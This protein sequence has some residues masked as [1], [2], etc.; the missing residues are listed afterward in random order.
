MQD[1]SLVLPHLT[2]SAGR[3]RRRWIQQGASCLWCCV[4]P[5]SRRG[6]LPHGRTAGA[7]G[8]ETG[9]ESERD[10]VMMSG[11]LRLA[12]RRSAGTR[13]SQSISL[14]WCRCRGWC[15]PEC[16]TLDSPSAPSAS[17]R[18]SLA[19]GGSWSYFPPGPG[20]WSLP[21]LWMGQKNWLILDFFKININLL[22]SP[23]LSS[24]DHFLSVSKHMFIM[25]SARQ[26]R[27]L[28]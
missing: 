7:G 20:Q 9:R 19:R 4:S 12:P 14:L 8:R 24:T 18:G 16:R 22:E 28:G 27:R 25:S 15:P 17:S 26:H 21:F 6:T 5:W 3:G 2:L 23:T 1:F 13:V 11:C 10:V